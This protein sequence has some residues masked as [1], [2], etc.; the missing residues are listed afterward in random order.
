MICTEFDGY[1]KDF[2][3]VQLNIS[4]KIT[5]TDGTIVYGDYER[6]G[7]EN[8]WNRLRG[9]CAENDLAI[10]T[11]ELYMFG[12]TH[13]VFFEDE[14]GLDGVFIVRGAAKDQAMDG[15][16]SRSFQTLTVGLLKEDCSEINVRKFCWPINEFEQG[17]SVRGLS[18]ENLNKMIFKNESK[19][20]QHPEVQ[21]HLYGTTV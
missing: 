12:A 7:L 3:H 20:Q 9:H 8:P 5:L 16:F 14:N 6:P 11:I 15:S 2:C 17:S 21:E 13:H 18:Y 1:M 4:W 19:K 10:T